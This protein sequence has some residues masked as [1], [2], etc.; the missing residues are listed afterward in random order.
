MYGSV[1]KLAKLSFVYYHIMDVIKYLTNIIY[2]NNFIER[3]TIFLVN[4][5]EPLLKYLYS[6]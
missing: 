5:A 4:I 6:F 1:T 2:K 3:T